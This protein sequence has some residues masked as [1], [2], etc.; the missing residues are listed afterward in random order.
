MWGKTKIPTENERK[1][2]QEVIKSFIESTIRKCVAELLDKILNT[3]IANSL[4]L[5]QME[6]S[7]RS[8]SVTVEQLASR[9]ED[10]ADNTQK[11]FLEIKRKVE[12]LQQVSIAK[13]KKVELPPVAVAS[14]LIPNF[15][16]INLN[17]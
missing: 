16:V 3:G 9:L 11:S 17:I 15:T 12:E 1:P 10:I 4:K 5:M 14:L 13:E 6:A 7:L 8:Q 2:E